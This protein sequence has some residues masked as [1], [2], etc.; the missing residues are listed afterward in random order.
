MKPEVEKWWKQAERDLKSAKNSFKSKDYYVSSLLAQQS[1]EKALKAL[2]IKKFNELIKTHDL[3]FLANKIKLAEELIE[4]C[5]KLSKVYIETRYPDASG[6]LPSETF[7]KEDSL[8]HIN[9]AEEIIK[10][11]KKEI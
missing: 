1:V 6:R 7:S 3:V 11:I 5:D 10:W 4:L 2:Y 8:N 9:I